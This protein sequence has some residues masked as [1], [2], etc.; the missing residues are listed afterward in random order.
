MIKKFYYPIILFSLFFLCYYIGSFNK[1]PFADCVGFVM[2]VEK[3]EFMRNATATTHFLYTNTAILI[4]NITNLNA[5]EASRLLVVSS[6]A[7]TV[8]V[9]YLALRNLVDRNWIAI[10][11]TFIFGFSFSF[12]KNAEIVEVYT[13]NSLWISLLFLCIIQSFMLRKEKYIIL[14]GVFLGI[15][16]WIHIQNILLIPA[17]FLFLFYFKSQ[18]KA[19]CYS[20]L[21]F[22]TLFASLF[23]LNFFQDLPF[24]SPY[25][26][27]QGNWVENSLK[28]TTI[29]YIQDLGKSV[30]YLFYN[31]NVFT[32]FGFV[33]MS[34]LYRS[35]RKMFFVFFTASILVYGFSTFYAVSDNYVF[36]IPFNI[37]F[38]LSIGY[39]L[40]S[41][42][43]SFMRKISWICM[44][45]P[46]L[47]YLSFKIVLLTEK[48]QEFNNFKSYKGGLEYYMLPWMNNN[49]GIVEFTIDKKTATEPI[50]WM[51]VSAEEYI[52]VLKSKGYKEEEIR[53]F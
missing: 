5:I 25:T 40:S 3:G 51:T 44:L 28:K 39:G 48:G 23:I 6:A 21:I 31:F 17:F 15:S 47:Y 20:L 37:I 29:Q 45:I 49:I 22:L 2:L 43:Y 27:D 41:I 30:V 7:A 12:W 14:S 10:T 8:S 32:F 26:S 18:Q 1:I 36:F 11:T 4:K 35:N 24:N 19:I 16:L 9:V 52:R 33:G 34:L 42:R 46:A 50:N 13:Y 53:K 38:A